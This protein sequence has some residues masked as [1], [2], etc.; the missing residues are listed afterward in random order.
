MQKH[1]T[2][3]Q[4][5]N[6]RAA[7]FSIIILVGFIVAPGAADIASLKQGTVGVAQTGKVLRIATVL[8][9]AMAAFWFVATKRCLGFILR[10]NLGILFVYFLLAL[11][12]VVFSKLK[13]MT[14]Y[15]SFEILA[16]ILV[17]TTVYC[18]VDRLKEARRFISGI[19]WFYVFTVG[20]VWIQFFIFGPEGQRQ[21][22]G[23]TPLLSFMLS[24]KYP[25]M[26][27]NALG[28]LGALGTLF[29]LYI[30][31]CSVSPSLRNKLLG[32][33]IFMFSL[34]IVIL[35]YTRSILVFLIL[36]IMVYFFINRRFIML[37]LIT[38][39]LIVPLIIPDAR[40]KIVEHMKRGSSDQ[41]IYTLS[42][43]IN[44]WKHVLERDTL[45]MMLGEG[46][47]SGT[48]FQSY[49]NSKWWKEKKI[50]GPRNAHNSIFE[51]IMSSGYIGA[52]I[53]MILMLR[54]LWQLIVFY[55]NFRGKIGDAELRFHKF[56]MAVFILSFMRSTMNSTFVYLDYFFFVLV[57]LAVYCDVLSKRA[58]DFCTRRP[59]VRGTAS[60]SKETATANL[61]WGNPDF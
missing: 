38:I 7:L 61:C 18:Y 26:V 1:N 36:A 11:L 3:K 22:V 51:I 30:G 45:Q 29:G 5:V 40:E 14:L 52:T 15:K 13:M 48:L 10:G 58:R 47:A 57:T 24:S 9:A 42:G 21:L 49:S 2:V 46:F 54:I 4:L 32:A 6:N 53:W 41:K 25:G 16:V 55:I 44:F 33:S 50:F 27:G 12:S 60:R 43:R 31:D 34:P 39:I 20:L 56:A 59:I 37:L 23:E 17:G 28:F 35:S 8:L 19:F